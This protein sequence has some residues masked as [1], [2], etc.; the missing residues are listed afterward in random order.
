MKSI[1]MKNLV[2]LLLFLNGITCLADEQCHFRMCVNLLDGKTDAYVISD[3]PVVSFDESNVNITSNKISISYEIGNIIDY[4]FER[5]QS[6]DIENPIEENVR[7]NVQ[8]MGNNTISINGIKS[9]KSIKIFSLN[10]QLENANITINDSM[11]IVSL[12]D[13]V[14]G[15]HIINID[16]QVSIKIYKK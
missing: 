4:T 13:L 14:N 15:C 9:P 5:I 10:G 11:A 3:Y 8:Y 7:Y 12:A 1:L 6:T 2:V 16:N